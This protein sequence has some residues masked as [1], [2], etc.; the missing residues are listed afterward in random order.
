ML[1]RL[2]R[3]AEL[4]YYTLYFAEQ[5]KLLSDLASKFSLML[6]GPTLPMAVSCP[7]ANVG[8]NITNWLNNVVYL[9]NVKG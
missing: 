7:L 8:K 4:A 9:D 5:L 2:H 1:Q 6:I 3:A